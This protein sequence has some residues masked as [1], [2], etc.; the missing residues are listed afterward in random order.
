[1]S[2]LQRQIFDILMDAGVEPAIVNQ[3]L[4]LLDTDG[5]SATEGPR[6]TR[7]VISNETAGAATTNVPGL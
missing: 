6:C 3:I 5:E 1:M 4:D 2:D 7:A